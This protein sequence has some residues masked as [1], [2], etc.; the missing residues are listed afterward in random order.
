MVYLHDGSDGSR[1]V[2][3]SAMLLLVRG[4]S[5]PAMMKTLAPGE[6]DQLDVSQ[7]AALRDVNAVLSAKHRLAGNHYEH[8]RAVPW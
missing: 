4:W 3:T 5:W 1:A 7:V 8:L 6:W 2:V